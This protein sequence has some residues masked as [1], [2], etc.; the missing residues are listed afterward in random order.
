[1]KNSQAKRPKNSVKIG[2]IFQL[3]KHLLL[4]GDSTR[5]EQVETLLNNSKVKLILTDPPYGVGYVENE[6]KTA[7][8]NE[9]V[10]YDP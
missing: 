3:G 8:N 5:S 2:D 9:K 1:M 6:K 10:F 4:C 7:K